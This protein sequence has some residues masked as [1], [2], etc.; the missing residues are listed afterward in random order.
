MYMRPDFPK[1]VL[2][3]L[4][5]KIQF[6]LPSVSDINAPAAHVLNTAKG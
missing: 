1:G 5:F 3:M 4:S 2:Y 6:S